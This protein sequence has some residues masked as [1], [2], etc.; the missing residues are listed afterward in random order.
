MSW[1]LNIGFFIVIGSFLINAAFMLFSPRRWYQLPWWIRGK[2]RGE[3]PIMDIKGGKVF[4]GVMGAFFLLVA[5]V[6]LYG[7]FFRK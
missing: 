4:L 6:F 5:L 1:I 7:Y 3:V 2:S